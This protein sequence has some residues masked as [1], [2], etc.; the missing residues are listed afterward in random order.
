MATANLSSQKYRTHKSLAQQIWV[1]LTDPSPH[2]TDKTEQR[3][4]RLTSVLLLIV[5][6]TTIAGTLAGAPILSVPIIASVLYA[7]SRTQ[8]V[9]LAG[10]VVLISL[11]IPSY[12]QLSVFAQS[13]TEAQ[14]LIA[15]LWLLLP[16]LLSHLLFNFWWSAAL[17]WFFIVPVIVMRF[18]VLSTVTDGTY[19]SLVAQ[20]ST[21]TGVLVTSSAIRQYY[22]VQRQLDDMTA[23]QR[24][25][26]RTNNELEVV[27]KEVRDFAYIVAHD[28][29]APIVNFEGFLEDMKDNLDTL[30][31]AVMDETNPK[32]MDLLTDDIPMSFGFML[33]S[34][35]KMKMLTNGILELSRVGRRNLSIEVVNSENIVRSAISSLHHTIEE[36]AIDVTVETLP[37]VHADA[38]A[39]S[40]I[41]S[42]FVD[43]AIKY[44]HPHRQAKI[45][46]YSELKPDENIFHIKDNGTGIAKHNY[47]KVFQPFRRL[48]S[49]GV[50]DG[51]GLSYIQTLIRLHGG[52]VWFSSEENIGTTFSFSIPKR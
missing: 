15:G 42:N 34:L 1:W 10:V 19:V 20:L 46:I 18:S 48:V 44:R 50:G 45:H 43:N 21:L 38:V 9:R 4:A 31:L 39:L 51:M 14:L 8:L 47:D 35:Q 5:I 22:L 33:V 25:L 32:V 40:Q 30:T 52:R 2:I 41:F 26:Q 29:R 13:G 3:L 28:L 24:D 16:I 49:D 7:I 11:A 17:S 6:V 12:L 36:H 23:I 37:I 27:N